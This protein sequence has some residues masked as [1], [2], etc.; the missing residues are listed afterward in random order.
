[1][2]LDDLFLWYLGDPAT[3]LPVGA[4]KLVAAGKGGSLRYGQTWL[5]R[6]FALSEDLPLVDVEHLPP[7]RLA[8]DAQRA[9]GAVDDARP[10]RGEAAADVAE[11]IAVVDGWQAHFAEAGVTSRDI[12]SLADRIDDE[13]LRGQR[14]AFDPAVF[15]AAPTRRKRGSPFGS[16]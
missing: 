6:G 13:A 9:A 7:G 11:V 4:L 10:D 14:A 1:M 2:R 15:Q 3:P 8:A 12:E 5:E 16:G